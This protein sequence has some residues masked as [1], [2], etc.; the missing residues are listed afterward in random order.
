LSSRGPE[1]TV[2]VDSKAD[3]VSSRFKMCKTAD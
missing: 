2:P 3:K 1:D